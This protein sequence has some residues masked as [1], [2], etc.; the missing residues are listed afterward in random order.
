MLFYLIYFFQMSE[1]TSSTGFA[2]STTTQ[3]NIDSNNDEYDDD[4]NEVEQIIA[5]IKIWVPIA[6]T[7][8]LVLL[9]CFVTIRS[10]ARRRRARE[11]GTSDPMR[12]ISGGVPTSK[13]SLS[14]NY[15]DD[16]FFASR[17]ECISEL[18]HVR[19]T[20][21]GDWGRTLWHDSSGGAATRLLL[22]ASTFL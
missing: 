19:S 22:R 15:S 5:A 12:T 8:V 7:L 16:K 2:F 6:L 18:W 20:A 3:R 9:L 4:Y 14:F 13:T 17:C 10:K 11:A 21:A 1:M